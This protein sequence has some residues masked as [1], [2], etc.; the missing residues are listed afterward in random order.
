MIYC[1][2]FNDRF[3][4]LHNTTASSVGM[5]KFSGGFHLQ[6]SQLLDLDRCA[7]TDAHAWDTS[8]SFDLLMAIAQFRIDCI[9]CAD[10]TDSIAMA[11]IYMQVVRSYVMTAQGEIYR[12]TQGNPSGSCNTI[13]DNT[14]GHYV[15]KAYAWLKL[16]YPT[17]NPD[18]ADVYYTDFKK[19]V[20]MLLFGDDD[21]MSVSK[22]ASSWFT[23]SGIVEQTADLGFEFTQENN[24]YTPI[25]SLS[26]L[27]HNFVKVKGF[28]V[29]Y[30]SLDRLKSA[31]VYSRSDDLHIRA[32]RL[33]NLRY[34][35]FYT[36]GWLPIIDRIIARFL[37]LHPEHQDV[38]DLSLSDREIEHLYLPFE[39]GLGKKFSRILKDDRLRRYGSQ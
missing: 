33:S 21:M 18:L 30:L 14:L 15:V 34:E 35:G 23:P 10:W 39:S 32:Q 38:F 13:V 5:S 4:T 37:Y 2:D 27:S 3:Y 25:L 8:M 19:N 31:V 28:L 24:E 9:S 17:L 29:P 22:E 1:K 16:T 20:T 26:Y 7:S 11:N 6:F 36:P 12:K